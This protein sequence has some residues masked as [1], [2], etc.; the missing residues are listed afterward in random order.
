LRTQQILFSFAVALMLGAA[1]CRKQEDVKSSAS[2]L[3]RAFQTTTA[4]AVAANPAPAAQTAA[5]GA[6]ELVKTALAAARVDDYASG[7]IALEAAGRKPGVTAEQVMAVQRALLAM[8]SDLATRAANGDPKALA[9]L[10][11]IEQT[12]SQ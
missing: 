2:E 3:E 1:S 9:Q 8:T 4:A 12:R 11:A 7:V 10:K 5:A 6:E